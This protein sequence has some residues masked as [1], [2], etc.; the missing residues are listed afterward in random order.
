VAEEAAYVFGEVDC[1][2][3]TGLLQVL[4]GAAAL[5]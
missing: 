2:L 3:I 4:V 1:A 5:V